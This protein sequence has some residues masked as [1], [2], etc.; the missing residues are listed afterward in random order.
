MAAL[1]TSDIIRACVDS[2]SSQQNEYTQHMGES[3]AALEAYQHYLDEW[4]RQ[5]EQEARQ[6]DDRRL[7][8]ERQRREIMREQC[9]DSVLVAQLDQARAEIRALREQLMASG[10]PTES[11]PSAGG[12]SRPSE[13]ATATRP[14]TDTF[15]R[16][17]NSVAKQFQK[18]RSQQAAR[19]AAQ[20]PT[21][22]EMT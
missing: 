4:Q 10:K 20:S 14:T 16:S 19:R 21:D 3:L 22:G 18:L 13:P 15:Q 17:M 5:I 8:L 12:G 1:D 2:W 7:E 6:M 11:A 9:D